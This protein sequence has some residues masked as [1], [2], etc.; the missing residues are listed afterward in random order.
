MTTTVFM[1]AFIVMMTM[2]MIIIII[3]FQLNFLGLT[4]VSGCKGFSNFTATNSVP[5]FRV[6]WWFGRTS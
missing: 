3:I 4:A 1:A 2:M 5:I 6:C